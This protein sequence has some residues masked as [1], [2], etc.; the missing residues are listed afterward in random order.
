M[1]SQYGSACDVDHIC[2]EQPLEEPKWDDSS[3]WS[4]LHINS[5][6]TIEHHLK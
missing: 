5:Y 2:L 6:E 3:P 1:Y 4:M